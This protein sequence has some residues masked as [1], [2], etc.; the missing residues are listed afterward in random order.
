[1]ASTITPP[2]NT[3]DNPVALG[4]IITQVKDWIEK[5]GWIWVEAQV[6]EITRRKGFTQF[7]TLRDLDS[8]NSARVTCTAQILDAQGPIT[9]GTTVTACVTPRLWQ[10]NSSFS[11]ECREL[12]AVGEGR[13]LAML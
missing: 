2:R 9:E 5:C 3:P 7:L 1:M 10:T 4:T 8:Q 6:I 12:R 11:F 13:L